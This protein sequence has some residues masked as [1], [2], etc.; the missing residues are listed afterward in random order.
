MTL[1][2]EIRTRGTH[3]LCRCSRARCRSHYETQQVRVLSQHLTA[4]PVGTRRRPQTRDPTAAGAPRTG[5]CAV[6]SRAE[7]PG[8]RLTRHGAR[9]RSPH[10]ARS[11]SRGRKTPGHAHLY[12]P[13]PRGPHP[14]QLFLVNPPFL[15]SLRL[16]PPHP[17]APLP[18]P[19]EPRVMAHLPPSSPRLRTE[20]LWPA[21]PGGGIEPPEAMQGVPS[22]LLSS[23]EKL[24]LGVFLHVP[25]SECILS[26]RLPI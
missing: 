25:R 2:N 13:P 26:P 17:A 24:S 18:L 14:L 22:L 20:R 19:C 12:N 8:T 5:A 3:G 23:S 11:P 4:T 6:L 21:R 15:R 16:S 1:L 10:S 7:H 9:A